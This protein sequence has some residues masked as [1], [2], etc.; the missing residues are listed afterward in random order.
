MNTYTIVV[1]NDGDTYS[2]IN[3]CKIITVTEEAINAL[4]NGDVTIKDIVHDSRKYV[5]SNIEL[6]E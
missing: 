4:D 2:G 5:L 1:L 6:S 3:G